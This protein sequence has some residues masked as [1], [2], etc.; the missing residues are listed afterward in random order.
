MY[1]Q[2]RNNPGMQA[3]DNQAHPAFTRKPA[4]FLAV[5]QSVSCSSQGII[6]RGFISMG[7]CFQPVFG[8]PWGPVNAT[9]QM[10]I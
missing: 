1:I 8:R 3:V 9:V 5:S 10:R 6:P 4:E 7:L 2:L